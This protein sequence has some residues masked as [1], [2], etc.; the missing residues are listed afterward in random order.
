[1]THAVLIAGNSKEFLDEVT[2]FSRYLRKYALV[3][4]QII[5]TAYMTK[6]RFSRKLMNIFQKKKDEPLLFVY[7]GHGEKTGWKINESNLFPYDALQGLLNF[8]GRETV[9]VNDCCYSG[10]LISVCRDFEDSP[11]DLEIIASSEE[12]HRCVGGLLDDIEEQWSQRLDF[13]SSSRPYIYKTPQRKKV[14]NPGIQ[15]RWG[16]TFDYMF[17][18]KN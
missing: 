4:T 3:S 12:N 7:C 14:T 1:M 13:E 16:N 18:P 15:V 5:A 10:S 17:F 9:I 8:R 2:E 6:K 11:D